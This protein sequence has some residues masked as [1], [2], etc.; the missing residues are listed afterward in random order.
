MIQ[1]NCRIDVNG[2]IRFFDQDILIDDY[3][4]NDY[5]EVELIVSYNTPGFGIVLF[6][7]TNN[8]LSSESEVFVFRIGYREAS[9]EYKAGYLSRTV[10]TVPT[11][12]IPDANNNNL[13]VVFKKYKKNIYFSVNDK[14]IF[15][16]KL[17]KLPKSISKFCIGFYSN[18]GNIIKYIQ[19]NSKIPDYWNINMFNTI[20][21]RIKFF[22]DGFNLSECDEKA[23]VEQMQIN[24]PAGKYYLQYNISSDSDIKCYVFESNSISIDDDEKD[25]L[26]HIDNS[27]ILEHDA[28]INIKFVGT[29]G[30]VSNII[31]N[32]DKNS[33]YVATNDDDKNVPSSNITINKKSL[34]KVEWSASI[35]AFGN[36][37]EKY[38]IK[39][40]LYTLLSFFG[41]NGSF[42][43]NQTYIYVY[44]LANSKITIRNNDNVILY[45]VDIS[46]E[47]INTNS[48]SILRNVDATIYY[49]TI[50]EEDGTETNIATDNTKK[51]SVSLNRHEPIIITDEYDEPLNISSAYRI[52]TT[53]DKETGLIDN[54]NDNY[55][56][57]NIERE[58]FEPSQYNVYKTEYDISENINAVRAYGITQDTIDYDN[59]YRVTNNTN[60]IGLCCNNNYKQINNA[61]ITIS[62]LTNEII[63][64]C[65]I[66][67]YSY[68]IIDYLKDNSYC[69]NENFDK[70]VYEIEVSSSSSSLKY[71]FTTNANIISSDY[72][73][74]SLDDFDGDSCYLCIR[75]NNENGG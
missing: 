10:L 3:I 48:F 61:D 34:V 57:T 53:I 55:V 28:T 51:I 15:D 40:G 72:K 67:E 2:G 44:D 25:I 30:S 59:I 50:Y 29:S 41:T 43:L 32:T 9:I 6:N 58:V 37:E 5:A 16:T 52:Y 75:N 63:F 23:E 11:T 17:F 56:M 47:N 18:C 4:Y 70:Y 14:I 60:D 38:I 20:G 31:L 33:N 66:S 46:Q 64:S 73:I 24:L 22:N 19:S 42:E 8:L 62:K 36:K 7:N 65:D 54:S 49:L 68:I 1:N 12:I 13:K 74:I 21:G 35:S 71:Y 45:D 26:D 27:I 69:I 39:D